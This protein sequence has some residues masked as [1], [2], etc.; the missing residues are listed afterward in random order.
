MTATKPFYADFGSISHG[1][2]KPEDLIPS[3]LEALDS[4]KEAESLSNT[5]NVERYSRIDD[6]LS[7]IEQRMKHDTYY[8]AEDAMFDLNETLIDLLNEYAPPFAYFGSH[9][10]DGSDFGYWLSTDAIEDAVQDGTLVKVEAGV[11]WPDFH[12]DIEYVL[13]VNDHGNA[14]LFDANSRLELWAIV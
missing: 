10:G 5:P 2:L 1:T 11:H 6:A 14:A 7:D 13:E 3:F 4:L 9:E 8:E 12:P